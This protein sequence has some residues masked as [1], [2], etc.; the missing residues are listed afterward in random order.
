MKN[1][2]EPILHIV[3][4]ALRDSEQ[5]VRGA[6]SFALGQFAEHFQPEIVSHYESVLPHILN[7]LEDTSDDVQ[8]CSRRDYLKC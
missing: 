4:G 3:F 2:L 7:S 8:V 6:A 5:M 1:K